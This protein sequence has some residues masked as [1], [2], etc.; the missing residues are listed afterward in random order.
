MHRLFLKFKTRYYAMNWIQ[1]EN[2]VFQNVFPFKLK[3]SSFSGL[4]WLEKFTLK[5]PKAFNISLKLR[6]Q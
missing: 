5:C 6:L 3:F 1:Q 4:E 2:G